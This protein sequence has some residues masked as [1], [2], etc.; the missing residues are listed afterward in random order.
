MKESSVR[1]VLLALLVGAAVLGGCL[2]GGGGG[3][4]AN[5]IP[6]SIESE[7]ISG[8][9][10]GFSMALS[11]GNQ[12]AC[13]KFFSPDARILGQTS[14][15][16]R[17]IFFPDFSQGFNVASSGASFTLEILEGT[18]GISILSPSIA[19]V[20]A[21]F[22]GGKLQEIWVVFDLLK[23]EDVWYIQEIT[24]IQAELYFRIVAPLSAT[25]TAGVM[26]R[27]EIAAVGGVPSY[28]WS[29][30]S[31]PPWGMTIFPPNQPLA[32]LSGVPTSAGPATVTIRL[33]D[34]SSPVRQ[35]ATRTISLMIAP[36]QIMSVS[37]PQFA[38]GTIGASFS[39]DLTVTGGTP[40]YIWTVATLPTGLGLAPNSARITGTPQAAGNFQVDVKVTDS[41]STTAN[42]VLTIRVSSLQIS[43]ANLVPGTIRTN[44]SHGLAATGGQAPYTWTVTGLPSGVSFNTA[45][46]TI[47]GIPVVSGSFTALVT[48]V[49]SASPAAM[50]SQPLVLSI[51]DLGFNF[52]SPNLANGTGRM[53]F[54][55][56]L[57]V[58][59]G[60]GP[61]IWT[62]SNLPSGLAFNPA[63]LTI[64]G[65]PM[66]TGSPT[67][68][69]SVCDS[70]DMPATITQTLTFSLV[71]LNFLIAATGNA[72]GTRRNFFSHPLSATG[73]IPPYT[74]TFSSLPNGL[75]FDPASKSII[76]I[77]MVFGA[78]GVT[79]SVMD[80][81]DAPATVTQTLSLSI[82]D[83]PP[84]QITSSAV[85]TG[86]IGFDCSFDL[87]ATGGQP[88]L[89]SQVAYD[90][91]IEAG[92][93][94]TGWTLDSTIGRLTG[95]P[96]ATGTFPV[97]VRA[98]D[99][100]SAPVFV[101]QNLVINIVP[102]KPAKVLA[103]KSGPN[104]VSVGF[105][106]LFD[107]PL[108]VTLLSARNPSNYNLFDE[109][110]NKTT[111][112][113]TPVPLSINA[114][115][116]GTG[117]T[118]TLTVSSSLT[119]S[120]LYMQA[121]NIVGSGAWYVSDPTPVRL[122]NTIHCFNYFP[123]G[124]FGETTSPLHFKMPDEDQGEMFLMY[125]DHVA[126]V[127]LSE[128][129]SGSNLVINPSR[130]LLFDDLASNYEFCDINFEFDTS[131]VL[132]TITALIRDSVSGELFIAER[133]IDKT[134]PTIVS[135]L[136]VNEGALPADSWFERWNIPYNGSESYVLNLNWGDLARTLD[137]TTGYTGIATYPSMAGGVMPVA[138]D[139]GFETENKASSVFLDSNGQLYE[140]NLSAAG[141]ITITASFTMSTGFSSTGCMLWMNSILDR[142]Q[143]YL[144]TNTSANTLFYQTTTTRNWITGSEAPGGTIR[145]RLANPRGVAVFLSEYK[146]SGDDFRSFWIL[147]PDDTGI[148]IFRHL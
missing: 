35:V 98:T 125:R 106:D 59:G 130:R 107:A 147:V 81:A 67:V 19:K 84:L 85:A 111:S 56:V 63:N 43:S 101:D 22:T 91:S 24:E 54:S 134:Y 140:Y 20:T 53:Q 75:G 48:V 105:R 61:Y 36:P 34:S 49:D 47:T 82:A 4:G 28:T 102:P 88:L 114:L 92:A 97:T 65:I 38:F 94:P 78:F 116:T 103:W 41:A 68:T 8:I 58:N 7:S 126:A 123:W 10:Q 64:S 136:G 17:K 9:L 15:N 124:T 121:F 148:Q 23:I 139:T 25:G 138:F 73:G 100:A 37:S 109:Q 87:T 127:P 89:I 76:G 12:E 33:T 112:V 72:A 66:T 128:G 77:P 42:Q 26:F 110:T 45:N 83:L 51:A 142:P 2:G 71:D 141:A 90:W 132:A 120:T 79:V 143:E 133:D 131:D 11:S 44:I 1:L 30:D 117:A 96:T 13:L 69:V 129:A 104:Q 135:N 145:G 95:T 86:C 29:I 31:A 3:G 52:T 62:L 60:V 5:S 50:V 80:S 40:P 70:A 16:V 137:E 146:P 99:R 122:G 118:Y 108:D 14:Q 144:L 74:Y 6:V 18:R 46:S 27:Q 119:P 113:S 21:R 55:H 57:G 39:H 32:V 115:I 93:L